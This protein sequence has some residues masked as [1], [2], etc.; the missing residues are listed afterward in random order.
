[1]RSIWPWRAF[2][3]AGR[4]IAKRRSDGAIGRATARRGRIAYR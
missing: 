3:G 2:Y 4:R 1:L